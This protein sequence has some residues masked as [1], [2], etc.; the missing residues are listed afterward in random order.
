MLLIMKI[1]RNFLSYNNSYIYLSELIYLKLLSKFNLLIIKKIKKSQKF[2]NIKLQCFNNFNIYFIKK[3]RIYTKLKYSRVPQFDT[4]SGAIASLLAALI[5]FM[6]TEKF[7]FEMLD[8]GDFY[9]I[10]MYVLFVVIIFKIN[11]KLI[12]NDG[13][14]F[15]NYINFF[16]LYYN[17]VLLIF[18]NFIKNN[19][20]NF[21]NLIINILYRKN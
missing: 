10:I 18:L 19:L 15:F 4:S 12:V 9:M 8:S 16:F 17:T 11:I 5:G 21:Y 14:G 7:G 3:E 13:F 6:I 2:H 20:I 1:S